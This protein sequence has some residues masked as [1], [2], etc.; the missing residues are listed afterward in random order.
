MSGH[1][2]TI[3]LAHSLTGR[4]F[5]LAI[6]LA[7]WITTFIA[8]MTVITMWVCTA[9]KYGKAYREYEQRY[10]EPYRSPLEANKSNRITLQ[11]ARGLE[12]RVGNSYKRLCLLGELLNQSALALLLKALVI[13]PLIRLT[14]RLKLLV[15]HLV[16]SRRHRW[17]LHDVNANDKLSD[18]RPH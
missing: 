14:E 18:E 5:A 2:P 3:L 4:S 8:L 13:R 17:W 15:G 7:C 9:L 10:G 6:L 1:L 11:C 16:G 12:L